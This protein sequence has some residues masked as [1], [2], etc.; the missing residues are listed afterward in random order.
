MRRSKIGQLPQDV[1]DA[2]NARLIGSNFSDYDGLA[3]WLAEQGYDISRS[4]LHRHGTGLEAEFEEAMADARRT[5]ALARAARESDDRDDGALLEAASGIMQDSLLRA[6]LKLKQ[7]DSD[8]PA[9]TAKTLS[10]I[11]RAFAD[12]GRFDLSR[13]KWQA[14][15]EEAAR[16]KLVE[17]QRAKLG[18]LGKTGAIDPETLARVMK[19]AYDL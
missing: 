16:K 7:G 19:A 13:Q 3:V 17:E 12:V 15:I 1:L 6:S 4:S 5:R 8:D 9:E 14:E 11:S 10:L 2:L 18:E